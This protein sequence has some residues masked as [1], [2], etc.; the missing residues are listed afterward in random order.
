MSDDEEAFSTAEVARALSRLGGA[1]QVRLSDLSR[2]W[3]RKVDP[4]LADDL[5]NESIARAMDG[6]R[7]W[8]M[9]LD[10]MTFLSGAMRSIADEW[11]RKA[12]RER[13][14]PP[15]DLEVLAAPVA[16]AQEAATALSK[17]VRSME[18]ALRGHPLALA[19]FT[20]RATGATEPEICVALGLDDRAYDTAY[21]RVQRELLRLFPEGCP[22]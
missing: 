16:P 2:V 6:R 17:L 5:L 22:L 11:G 14:V 3:A 12:A 15:G 7:R 13:A 10:L 20:H 19:I 8:P 9:S 4:S 1:D 18:H 21:R